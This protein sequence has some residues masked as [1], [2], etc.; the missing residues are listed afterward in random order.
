MQPTDKFIITPKVTGT[1]KVKTNTGRSHEFVVLSCHLIQRFKLSV[2]AIGL[3]ATIASSGAAS[4]G[5]SKSASNASFTALELSRQ[6]D[7]SLENIMSCL[8]ELYK[9]KCIELEKDKKKAVNVDKTLTAK[10]EYEKSKLEPHY[11]R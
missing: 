1:M 8:M 9:V 7:D 2:K 10:V 4:K 3:L 5:S 11:A 6:W